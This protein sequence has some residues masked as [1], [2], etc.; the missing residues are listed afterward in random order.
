MP[1]S[2]ITQDHVTLLKDIA[3]TLEKI[4]STFNPLPTDP[5][6]MVDE[7]QYNPNG[8]TVTLNP[9]MQY[10]AL[11]QS[12]IASIPGGTSGVLTIGAPGSTGIKRQISIVPGQAPLNNIAMIIYPSDAFILTTT[13]GSGLLYIEIMGLALKG[14]EWRV[15]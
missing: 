10:P 13:G 3:S 15:I 12:I 1:A 2:E 14:Q 8:S 4:H 6:V 7:Y 5:F 11:I 9:Q